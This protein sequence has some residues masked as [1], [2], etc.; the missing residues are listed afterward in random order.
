MQSDIA[1]LFAEFQKLLD[2][3]IDVV[4]EDLVHELEIADIELTHESL[5]RK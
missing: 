2:K 5:T 3:K 4:K 1:R